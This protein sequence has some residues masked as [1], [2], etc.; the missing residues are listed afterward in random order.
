MP[1]E[2]QRIGAS[3]EH[4]VGHTLDAYKT[5]GIA[6]LDFLP[7]P[8]KPVASGRRVLDGVSPY[9]VYGYS[10]TGMNAGTFI[11]AELKAS[12]QP[13][14]RLPITEG[15]GRGVRTFQLS[16]LA[17]VARH[18]GIARLVWSNA[19]AVGV[20]ENASIIN[21]WLTC[22]A[23]LRSKARGLRG[24]KRGSMSI[25]WSEFRVVSR[26]VINGV[27]IDFDWLDLTK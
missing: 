15:R 5:L 14:E 23:T 25:A 7:V 27:T 18:N 2:Q 22:E 26:R 3:F 8:T 11:A 9:D 10:L 21:N 16:A 6:L 13:H 12:T 17:T 4:D 1:I 20:L 19:G 24:G